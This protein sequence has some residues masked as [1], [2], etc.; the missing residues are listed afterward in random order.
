MIQFGRCMASIGQQNQVPGPH[1]SLFSPSFSLSLSTISLNVK[2]VPL[3]TR[4]STRYGSEVLFNCLSLYLSVASIV[5]DLGNYEDD[6][7][8]LESCE[9]VS[10]IPHPRLL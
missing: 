4:T 8:H 7:H 3:T 9:D 1:I 2:Y 10:I 6:A 5:S